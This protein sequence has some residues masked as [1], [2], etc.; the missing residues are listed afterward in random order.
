MNFKIPRIHRYA[1]VPEYTDK[2]VDMIKMKVI[3][4]ICNSV[5]IPLSMQKPKLIYVLENSMRV[6]NDYLITKISKDEQ[7]KLAKFVKYRSL[8]NF[9]VIGRHQTIFSPREEIYAKRNGYLHELITSSEN[10]IKWCID[11]DD[12]MGEKSAREYLEY[13]KDQQKTK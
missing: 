5:R 8:N 6:P 9:G 2:G 7:W 12:I 10:Q 4:I 13:F 3:R 11:N 1:Y